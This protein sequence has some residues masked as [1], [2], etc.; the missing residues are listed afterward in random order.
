[1]RYNH[2]ELETIYQSIMLETLQLTNPEL[3]K[4]K[5]I[6]DHIFWHK[7]MMFD[8]IPSTI[9]KDRK[10]RY[11]MSYNFL[12]KL[13]DVLIRI[14]DNQIEYLNND[15]L[16]TIE[17]DIYPVF[18]KPDSIKTL[19]SI[20]F[21]M[22]TEK[23]DASGYISAMSRYIDKKIQNGWNIKLDV[24]D[25]NW[26]FN[27]VDRALWTRLD[28]WENNRYLTSLLIAYLYCHKNEID[29]K[30]IHLHDIIEVY[31][32]NI[33]YYKELFILETGL[34]KRTY[35]KGEELQFYAHLDGII[36]NIINPARKLIR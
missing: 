8:D 3:A 24:N 20:F 22:E 23:K 7:V 16:D 31:L 13:L 28:E 17:F 14:P 36:Y 26:F 12:Q 4:Y 18:L 30:H 2:E 19:N 5:D 25:F 9:I 10:K 34:S 35:I 15:F 27:E 21:P 29:V 11:K 33:E 1:M 32:D 6:L